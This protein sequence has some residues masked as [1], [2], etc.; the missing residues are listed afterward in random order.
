M[1]IRVVF[2]RCMDPRYEPDALVYTFIPG[3]R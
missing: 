1:L 3:R 2:A